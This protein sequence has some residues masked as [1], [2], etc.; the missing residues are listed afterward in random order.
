M[1]RVKSNYIALHVLKTA[2]PRLR[3]ALTSNSSKEL[4]DW[5]S[6][7]ILS[8]L[9]GN[10]KLLVFNT[11]KLPKYKSAIRKFADSNVSL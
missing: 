1:K 7:C 3:K 6:E 9:N 11:H 10:L 2:Q 8:V 5:I 4:V